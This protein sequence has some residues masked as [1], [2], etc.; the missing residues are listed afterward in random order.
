[1]FNYSQEQASAIADALAEL[2]DN[3]ADRRFRDFVEID[4][5][6]VLAQRGKQL[7]AVFGGTAYSLFSGEVIDTDDDSRFEWVPVLVDG[8]LIAEF[9][10]EGRSGVLHLMRLTRRRGREVENPKWFASYLSGG[11]LNA[12]EL[13]QSNQQIIDNIADEVDDGLTPITGGRPGWA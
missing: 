13:N 11:W 9:P 5:T 1:M 12:S 4:R 10:E 6:G 3:C 8:H 2:R 7:F